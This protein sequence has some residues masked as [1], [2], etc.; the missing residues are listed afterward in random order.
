M[1]V[2]AADVGGAPPGLTGA[3]E[4]SATFDIVSVAT[5]FSYR[6]LADLRSSENVVIRFLAAYMCPT[7]AALSRALEVAVAPII[8]SVGSA[9][10]ALVPD[11][12]AV[13]EFHQAWIDALLSEWAS[14]AA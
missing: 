7:A 10:L 5:R 9:S 12:C 11:I 2:F 13:V 4:I 14:T 6:F 3:A 1:R 8:G